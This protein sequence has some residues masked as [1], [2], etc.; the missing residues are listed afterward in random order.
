M[1]EWH[2]R[3]IKGAY[4]QIFDFEKCILLRDTD[5]GIIKLHNFFSFFLIFY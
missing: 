5:R 3:I 2:E 1:N 4:E